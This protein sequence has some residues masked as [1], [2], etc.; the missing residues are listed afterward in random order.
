MTRL[1]YKSLLNRRVIAFLTALSVALSVLLYAS[2]D[3]LRDTSRQSFTRTVSGTHILA[4]ARSGQIPLLLFS[5]FHLGTPTSNVS[6]SSYVK[7]KKHGAVQ[8]ALPLVIGD[9]HRGFRV[10]GTSPDL[11]SHFRYGDRQSLKVASGKYTLARFRAVLGATAARTLRYKVGDKLVLTHGISDVQGIHDHDEKPFVIEAVFAPTGTPFDKGIYVSL[12][13]VEL[14]HDETDHHEHDSIK[15]DKLTSF[16]LGVKEP[17]DIL[18]LMRAINEDTAE[19]LTAILP[20]VVLGEIW[21]VMGYAENILKFVSFAVMLTAL[22][23]LFIALYASLSERTR[24]M[25]ILRALGMPPVKIA[26]LLVSESFLLVSL[27]IVFAYLILALTAN[28]AQNFLLSEFSVIINV[29]PLT[30]NE[31]TFLA[32][33]VVMSIIVALVP[34]LLIYRRA[35]SQGLKV[36]E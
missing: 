17:I 20:G 29:F 24:E 8:W 21:N 12:V 34:A 5:L 3:K 9:S 23:G 28:L 19:P 1:I 33:L 18:P 7:Y 26:S 13:S 32:G 25:A 16:M 31:I 14:M 2:V 27:G 36:K 11:I 6:Y 15:V 22:C 30:K 4:G 35:I 10:V